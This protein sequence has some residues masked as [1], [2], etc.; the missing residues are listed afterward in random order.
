MDVH[1]RTYDVLGRTYDVHGRT[2]TL[3]CF[4]EGSKIG[5]LLFPPEHGLRPVG[6]VHHLSPPQPSHPWWGSER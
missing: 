2:W 4:T 6:K 3:H 5:R 1:G